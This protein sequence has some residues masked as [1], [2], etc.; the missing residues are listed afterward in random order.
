MSNQGWNLIP[1]LC[2]R[3]S[4]DNL[5]S[6]LVGMAPILHLPPRCGFIVCSLQVTASEGEQEKQ[7][8]KGEHRKNKRRGGG[9]GAGDAGNMT[10]IERLSAAP[11]KTAPP[12]SL[13]PQDRYRAIRGA[14][15]WLR[16]GRLFGYVLDVSPTERECFPDPG[17]GSIG[18]RR[19]DM[20][21][22][23]ELLALKG[24]A[25]GALNALR[26]MRG[27]V[28]WHGGYAADGVAEGDDGTARVMAGKMPVPS[29]VYT[30]VVRTIG[31]R[32]LYSSKSMAAEELARSPFGALDWLL[33]DMAD[34]GYLVNT[35]TLNLG[36][37]AYF[38]SAGWRVVS[39][40]DVICLVEYVLFIV[41]ATLAAAVGAGDTI[42]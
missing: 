40:R 11:P 37:N 2:E 23:V 34:Q 39:V 24:D 29:R 12:P 41:V 16:R 9:N 35:K 38:R 20:M 22:G 32:N 5:H 6:F 30:K 42:T 18:D 27:E 8:S 13:S 1:E 21:D 19:G 7:S 36:L 4:C 14:N 17:H 28:D 15:R 26:A 31:V 33:R 3:L 10:A 25:L